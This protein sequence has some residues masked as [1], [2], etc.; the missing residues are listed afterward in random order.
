MT[1]ASSPD[2]VLADF[3]EAAAAADRAEEEYRRDHARRLEELARERTF[4][5]RRFNLVREMLTYAQAVEAPDGAANAALAA[6]RR[7]L[8]W[9]DDTPVR[10]AILGRLEP[11]AAAVAAI[12]LPGEPTEVDPGA[13]LGPALAAFESWHLA[14]YGAPFWALFDVYVPERPVVDF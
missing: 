6:V 12:A 1:P 2:A 8:N 7:E 13:E 10:T 3:R 4:A 5:Y 9:D 14:E 11:V